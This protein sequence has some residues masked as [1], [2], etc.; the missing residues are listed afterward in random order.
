MGRCKQES[1]RSSGPSYSPRGFD[2]A[3]VEA[4]RKTWDELGDREVL[5]MV[6]SDDGTKLTGSAEGSH[7]WTMPQT[8]RSDRRSDRAQLLSHEPDAFSES[9]RGCS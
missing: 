6:V 5:C 4:T 9:D 1:S 8:T 2:V 3:V 7:S